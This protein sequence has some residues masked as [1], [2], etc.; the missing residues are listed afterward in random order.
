LNKQKFC[1]FKHSVIF[2]QFS[3]QPVSFLVKLLTINQKGGKSEIYI[4]Q[5]PVE[6]GDARGKSFG[7]RKAYIL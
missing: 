6:L 3:K 1:A 2:F 5:E 7:H 4:Q